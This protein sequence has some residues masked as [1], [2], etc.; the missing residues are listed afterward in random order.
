MDRFSDYNGL[1]FGL[2]GV[3]ATFAPV[4]WGEEFRTSSQII[5]GMTPALVF[6]AFGNVI[7]T[8]FLIP[9]SFDKEY[10]VSL[11]YGAVVNILINIILIPKIRSNGSCYRNNCCR[12]SSMLLSNV[13]R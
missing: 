13:D 11:L 7:R 6:S 1:C 10:T 2:A 4:Y 8:Q 5:A 12:V 3:S 9:R